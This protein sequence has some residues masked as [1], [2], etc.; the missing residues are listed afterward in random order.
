MLYAAGQP[1]DRFY[2]LIEGRVRLTRDASRPKDGG[3]EGDED[4]D[5]DEDEEEE[6]EEEAKQD[7]ADAIGCGP[8]VHVT[9]HSPVAVS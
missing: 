3:G 8:A 4:E 6:E 1:S 9:S 5:E 7:V 2:V